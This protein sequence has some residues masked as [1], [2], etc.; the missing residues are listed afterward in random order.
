MEW[1]IDVKERLYINLANEILAKVITEQFPLGSKLPTLNELIKST[2]TSQ[3]T[4]RK[5]IRLLT[6][7]E[8]LIKTRNGYFITDKK[9]VLDKAK[10]KYIETENIR[11]KNVLDKIMGNGGDNMG[12]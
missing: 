11:H 10:K 4:M 8:I 5:A 12:K 6:Q 1:D 3:E 9:E 2:H 7:K